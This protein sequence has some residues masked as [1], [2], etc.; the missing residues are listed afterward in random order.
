VDDIQ[1]DLTRSQE[2]TMAT[3]Y[4]LDLTGLMPTTE[5]RGFLP[6]ELLS[7]KLQQTDIPRIAKDTRLTNLLEEAIHHI[8]TQHLLC[9]S[10]A[11]NMQ[12]LPIQKAHLIVTSPPYWTLKEYRENDSQLGHIESYDEFIVELDKVW[13]Q[14]YD[15]LVPGGRLICVVGDVCLS[16]RKNGGRHMVMPTSLLHTRAL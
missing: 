7:N 12:Q 4:S 9:H 6:D 8:P 5:L 16:R 15:V 11:R 13:K 3:A 10:D 2:N 1:N 14:C